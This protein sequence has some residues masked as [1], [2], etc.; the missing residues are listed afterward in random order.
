VT[1]PF[2]GLMVSGKPL[3]RRPLYAWN[4]GSK[5]FW[6]LEPRNFTENSTISAGTWNFLFPA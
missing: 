4:Y 3:T 5:H 2:I 6:N 1:I